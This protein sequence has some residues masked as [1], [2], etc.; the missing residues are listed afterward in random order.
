M[1]ERARAGGIGPGLAIIAGIAAAS[2]SVLSWAKATISS[3]SASAK[4]ID[5]WEGKATIAGAVILLVG[6][7]AAFLG[8]GGARARLR[9]SAFVGGGVVAGV[10]IYTALTAQ[11]QVI[12][13]AA[14]EIRKELGIPLEQART[15]VQQVL[16][17][18]AMKITLEVGLYL[19]IAGGLLGLAAALASLAAGGEAPV[20]SASAAGL[21]GWAAPTPS[22]P[23]PPAAGSPDVWTPSVPLPPP[24]TPGTTPD[25]VEPPATPQGEPSE[26]RQ[27]PAP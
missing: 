18:G 9:V 13:G 27:G 21:T 17:Q 2:G 11:D 25:R 4:G 19:V 3:F 26:G 12:D 7:I 14:A 6:G 15:A 24:P 5:G 16:D 8:A 23:S 22:S 1:Q 20:A 10:G